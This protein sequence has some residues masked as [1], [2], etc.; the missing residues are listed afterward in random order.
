MKLSF[1]LCI[2]LSIFFVSPAFGRDLSRKVE[3]CVVT[4]HALTDASESLAKR[5]CQMTSS[6]SIQT[7]VIQ[8][9]R[10]QKIR[11][12]AGFKICREQL[13]AEGFVAN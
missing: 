2:A 10:S 8:L 3:A 5:Y 6:Q 13:A 4:I 9:Y 12:W 11:A 1:I 7:C